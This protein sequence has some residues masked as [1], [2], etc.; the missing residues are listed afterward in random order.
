LEAQIRGMGYIIS[1]ASPLVTIKLDT[2]SFQFKFK[3]KRKLQKPKFS[4]EERRKIWSQNAT[5]N[6]GYK[7]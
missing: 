7:R 2:T 1:K 4:K 3:K 5:M 6:F